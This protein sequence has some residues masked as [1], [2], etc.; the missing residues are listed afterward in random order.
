MLLLNSGANVSVHDVPSGATPL[1][2][3]IRHEHERIAQELLLS[4]SN[5]NSPLGNGFTPLH[6][7]SALANE[8]SVKLLMEHGAIAN[9]LDYQGRTP[10]DVVG[11]AQIN[12][13]EDV[14]QRIQE[15]LDQGSN[16]AFVRLHLF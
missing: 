14:I 2:V 13:P 10:R 7:A 5:A 4:G 6:L 8:D 3:S 11:M 12:V 16:S 1:Y 9:I 15:L